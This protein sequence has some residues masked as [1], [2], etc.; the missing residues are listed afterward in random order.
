MEIN[1]N[2]CMKYFIDT[3]FLEGTQKEKFPIS[4]FRKNTKPTIDLISIGIVAEDGREYYA[5]SKDF[6]LKEAWSRFDW[7]QKKVNDGIPGAY[8]E[9]WIRGNVLKPIFIELR[10]KEVEEYNV[11]KRRN[12]VLDFPEYSFCFR[13]FKR[14]INKYGTT[15]KQIAEEVKEFCRGKVNERNADFREFVYSKDDVNR[16]NP[17]SAHGYYENRP[18]P[19]F[20]AYY[21]DYDWVVFCWLFGKMLDLPKSFPTYCIDLKQELD[22]KVLPL[23]TKEN[24]RRGFYRNTLCTFNEALDIF[25]TRKNYPKQTN[26]H[27]ALADA[28]WNFELYKFLQ[29][30]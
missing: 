18:N 19:E 1:I 7:K 6:N 5:I 24:Q 15:N 2:F 16:S 10:A 20:Y 8:R 14:L 23:M 26:E 3:E 11:A 22:S 25:K 12:V 28:K 29:K 17:Q 13:E 30:I 9:Y 21:A 4:L 27:N